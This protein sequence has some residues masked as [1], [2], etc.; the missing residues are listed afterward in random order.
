MMW[1]KSLANFI[2]NAEDFSLCI[3]ESTD[4]ND[5]AQCDIS[6]RLVDTNWSIAEELLDIIPMTSTATGE[7][8]M[9]IIEETFWKYDLQWDKLVSIATDGAKSMTVKK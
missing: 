3:D 9:L 6:I 4:I 1:I 8:F 2:Q 5:V 7:D